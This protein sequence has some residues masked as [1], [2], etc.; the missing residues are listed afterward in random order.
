MTPP[1]RFFCMHCKL[2]MKVG[3]QMFGRTVVCPQCGG[4][5]EVP[6]Q[7]D[8]KAEDLYRFMKQKRAEEKSAI[9]AISVVDAAVGKTSV[10]RPASAKSEPR[11]TDL[12]FQREKFEELEPDEVDRWIEEFWATIPENGDSAIRNVPVP[13]KRAE[14]QHSESEGF[15]GSVEDLAESYRN[16]SVR[17]LFRL[18]LAA[19]FVVG[20][21]AGFALHVAVRDADRSARNTM[22]TEDFSDKAVIRGELYYRGLDGRRIPDADAVVIFLPADRIPAVPISCTELGPGGGMGENRDGMTQIEELGGAFCRTGADGT[23]SQDFQRSGRYL[24]LMISAHVRRSGPEL[25]PE[26][27]LDLQRFFSDPAVLLGEYRFVR[28]EYEIGRGVHFIRE[29]FQ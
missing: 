5:L 28:E 4:R 7:S 17:I 23:F 9:S 15:I 1:V 26:T 13:K 21:F 14:R 12:P 20:L 19:V 8:P 25:P 29:T 16:R 11:T 10:S 24:A 6:F 2:M 3:P 22:Q 27:L 18:A